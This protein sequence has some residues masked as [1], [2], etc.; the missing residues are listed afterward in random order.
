MDIDDDVLTLLDISASEVDSVTASYTHTLP[1]NVMSATALITT[2]LLGQRA[3]SAS[4]LQGL[5]GIKVE[6]VEIRQSRDSQMARDEI[7]GNAQKLLA[8]YRRI[9]WGA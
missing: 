5:S 4:G 2:S 1:T 8:P 6:E 3:I 9:H 7:P